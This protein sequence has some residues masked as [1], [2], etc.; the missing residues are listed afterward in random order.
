M[1]PFSYILSLPVRLYRFL[2]SPWV[3][4]QCRYHPTC[5]AYMLAALEKHGA[6]KGLALG[7]ARI[8]RCNPW[9]G[10]GGHDPVPEE[11]TWR[12]LLGY[13]RTRKHQKD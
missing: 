1:S 4:N 6:L 3:G 12:G 9:H 7:I 8:I 11:F 5:S 2:F 13:N 10:C